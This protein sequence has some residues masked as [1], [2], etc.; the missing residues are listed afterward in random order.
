KQQRAVDRLKL[1]S[2]PRA[3]HVIYGVPKSRC[4]PSASHAKFCQ[5]STPSAAVGERRMERYGV[6]GSTS[7]ARRWASCWPFSY[8][9]CLIRR[10]TS[11]LT[12]QILPPTPDRCLS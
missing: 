3:L 1:E 5:S 11:I 8:S 12:S 2:G 6:G 7:C 10:T 9:A 4:S